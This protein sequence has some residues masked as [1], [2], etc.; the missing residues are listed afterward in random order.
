MYTLNPNPQSG[1]F[2]EKQRL[3]EI[4]KEIDARRLGDVVSASAFA[5][6]IEG[7]KCR[8]SSGRQSMLWLR[9]ILTVLVQFVVR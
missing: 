6:N 8:E 3:Q 7:Q 4:S 1:L 2:T 5:S 9:P